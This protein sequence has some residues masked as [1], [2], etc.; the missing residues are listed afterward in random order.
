G[1]T[2]PLL[3][4]LIDEHALRE[5]PR[6]DLLWSY[7]RN[8]IEP[9][10]AGHGGTPGG[11]GRR[12]AQE[13]GLPARLTGSGDLLAADPGRWRREIVIENDIAWRVQAMVDF[14]FSRPITLRSLAPSQALRPRIERALDLCFEASGGAALLADAG[15]L[16]H[17]YG[18][19]DL[20]LRRA[21][22]GR[23]P[24]PAPEGAPDPAP[25]RDPDDALDLAARALRIELI[26]PARGIPLQSPS[27]YRALS[28][29]ILR[30]DRPGPALPVSTHDS[31][32]TPRRTVETVTEIL[33]SAAHALFIDAHDGRG[34]RHIATTHNTV[35][36]GE[37]PVV[38]IQNV[39]QPFAYSGLSEV[40]PL[41]PLQDE[42]NTRMSDRASR[43]TLQCFKMYLARGIDGFNR[44]PVGPG[45]LWTT[46]NP[47]AH[48]D[49]FGGDA[50][51]PSEEAHIDE[52][53][54]ALD[55][56]SSLPPLA[57]GVVRA[58]IGNL[59]SENALRLTLQGVL[60]RTARKRLLYGRGIAHLCRLILTALDASGHLKT[61]PA[62]R[63]VRVEWPDPLPRTQNDE[64]E[65]AKARVEL[66][67]PR[68]DVL[69]SLGHGLGDSGVQ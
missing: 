35:S 37:V 17:V 43:V 58:K 23:A 45:Q 33:G 40:E 52:I 30:Y 27:D 9:R 10:P 5:V 4:H 19:V 36:H 50:A 21:T 42:L 67:I 29:Y 25:P 68:E 8:P 49:E 15:L 59:T 64:L 3:A 48:I 32:T 16:G 66:G 26:E 14:L 55:K 24:S 54:E 39:S 20:L 51:S 41:I 61:T 22:E 12:L 13:R 28:A 53:R 56:Q 1:L 47:D 60:T 2:E 18:H 44:V 57:T 63:A 11:R 38:H 34:S 62:E 46:S 65:A 69:Q 7:Y 6:N 31:G